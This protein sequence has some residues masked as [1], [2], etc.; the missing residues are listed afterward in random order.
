M[1]RSVTR[2]LLPL[3]TAALFLA[4]WRVFSYLK[5]YE[6]QTADGSVRRIEVFPTPLQVFTGTEAM[7]RDGVILKYTIASV[8]RVAVGFSL[9]CLIGIPLGLWVGWSTRASL[10]LN[11]LIQAIRPISPIAWI[12]V[13]ILLFGVKDAAAIFLVCLSSVFPL[14]TGTIAA[15]RS[16]PIVHVRAAQNFGLSGF[17]LY[18]RVL[19]PASLPQIV[20]SMRLALGVAWL[21]I[22]AAEMIAVDSGLGY[23]I[24]DS[25]NANYYDRVVGGMIC[26]GLVGFAL[27]WCVRRLEH[28][29]EVRWGFSKLS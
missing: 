27:D 25:R 14:A 11:P 12:P 18:R 26:I 17:A 1:P 20:T 5:E 19:F 21:V 9:A 6:L 16:I 4:A 15:V 22:V 23:M 8:Y 7:F 24:N 2:I 3:A 28:L 13:A 29:D 10:S